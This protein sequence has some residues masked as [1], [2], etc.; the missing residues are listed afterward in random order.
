LDNEAKKCI[1]C[2]YF[3]AIN[4]KCTFFEMEV[5]KNS[6]FLCQGFSPLEKNI[7]NEE[8]NDSE[9]TLPKIPESQLFVQTSSQE[10][11]TIEKPSLSNRILQ[12]KFV[13]SIFSILFTICFLLPVFYCIGENH[14][15]LL[16]QGIS[17]SI[18][19]YLFLILISILIKIGKFGVNELDQLFHEDGNKSKIILNLFISKEAYNEF[20][21]QF[22]KKLFNRK[23]ALVILIP[24]VLMIIYSVFNF[25]GPGIWIG[26]IRYTSNIFFDWF[27]V[28]I[29]DL[30]LFLWS[31]LVFLIIAVLINGL[32][33]LMQI[34]SDKEKLSLT[35]YMNN[36]KVIMF[37]R[38]LGE[39]DSKNLSTSYY[40]FQRSNR[41]I[42]EYL[43]R[44]TLYFMI[45]FTIV[46]FI[47]FL[48]YLFV[49]TFRTIAIS[50]IIGAVIFS[51][52]SLNIFIIPQIRLH[53]FL[54]NTK[55]ETIQIFKKK[56]EE[57]DNYFLLHYQ[58]IQLLEKINPKWKRVKG[59][60][61]EMVMLGLYQ[62]RI[63]RLSTWAYDLPDLLKLIMGSL[64]SVIPLIL[65]A[66]GLK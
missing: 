13:I 25:E 43:F 18:Y 27:A 54:K 47:T 34:Q 36:L 37:R 38:K 11:K 64:T 32:R 66:L 42:G 31:A 55:R 8:K 56:I 49:Q 39:L 22:Y 28:L 12:P 24:L 41:Y 58:D 46:S 3:D 2:L 23:I 30:T 20:S 63:E 7:E 17:E 40:T 60:K 45:L 14:P 1:E 65:S 21:E 6:I 5:T 59:L 15:E 26:G 33:A 19:Y 44:I 9:L 50:F 10:E 48:I 29:I 61:D 57:L 62:Q 4:S 51:I 16:I 53:F 35:T 52:L